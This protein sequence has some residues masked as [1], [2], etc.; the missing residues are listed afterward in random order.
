MLIGGL[1]GFAIGLLFGWAQRAGWPQILWHSAVAM[2][3]GGLL[4]RWW[5]G[6]WMRNL[7]AAQQ[8]QMSRPAP[9]PSRVT[10]T[11]SEPV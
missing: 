4:M 9:N 11:E 5:G 7:Q 10:Q 3:V 8:E 2:Y 6:V 1:I